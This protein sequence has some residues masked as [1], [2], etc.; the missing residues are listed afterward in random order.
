MSI[1]FL[2]TT[3]L[4]TLALGAAEI[5][6][7]VGVGL[8]TV[9]FE[10]KEGLVSQVAAATTNHLVCGNQTFAITSGT[11]GANPYKDIITNVRAKTFV[12]ENLDVLAREMAAGHGE[13]LGALAEI[14][15]VPGERRLAWQRTMQAHFVDIYT[16]PTVT[17]DE[18]LRNI[19]RL[20]G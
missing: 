17:H 16:S 20:C 2:L 1:R 5:R 10:G 11:L 18:V 15:G 7:N 9:I 3:G 14:I 12:H 4:C 13:S 19:A 6:D 8:G